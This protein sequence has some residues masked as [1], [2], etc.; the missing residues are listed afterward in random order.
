MRIFRHTEGLPDSVRGGTVT[1]GNFDGVHRGH[2]AVIGEARRVAAGLGGK[3]TVVTF[4]PHP[5]RFFRPGEPAFEL[6]PLRSKMRW[7][8]AI[9]IETLQLVRFD[10]EVSRAS[11]D[12]FVD[13]L[14]VDGLDARHVVVGYDFVFGNARRGDVAMLQGMADAGRF[15][16]TAVGPAKA[17]DGPVYSSTNIRKFLVEGEPAR[18]AALLGRCWEIE[19]RVR[20]G[21]RRGRQIGFPTANVALDQYVHPALGVYAV[22]AGI[23]RDG[24]TTWHMGCANIGRRPTF[25]GEGVVVE[26]H[27]FDFSDDIYDQLLRVALV[28]FIRPERK[29]DGIPELR[30]QIARDCVAARALLEGIG[31]DDPRGPPDHASTVGEKATGAA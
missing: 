1:I 4:E 6:T 3:L 10:D 29:F 31:P 26:A 28:G 11:A 14:L 13:Q 9:G 25:A 21:D 23:E 5:R 22:W 18:A 12:S 2:Q 17:P 15:G 30:E 19:G 8:Q 24:E 20:T 27:I 7:L 16:F